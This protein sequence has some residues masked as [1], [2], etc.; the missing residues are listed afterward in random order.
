MNRLPKLV[1]SVHFEIFSGHQF[2]RL[3]LAYHL[4]S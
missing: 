2:E 4:H 3:V 1:Q